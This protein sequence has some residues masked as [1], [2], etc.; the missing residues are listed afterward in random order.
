MNEK[1]IHEES[2]LRYVRAR[3]SITNREC[4]TL[5]GISY[6]NAIRLLGGLAASGTLDRVGVSSATKYVIADVA[7]RSSTPLSPEKEPPRSG[8]AQKPNRPKK[9]TE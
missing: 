8:G 4:R 6:D 2:V 7:A 3:G 1:S 5:L 9:R